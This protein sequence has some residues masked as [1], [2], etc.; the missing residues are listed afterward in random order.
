MVFSLLDLNEFPELLGV[1][2]FASCIQKN[3]VRLY[4]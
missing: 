3:A 2:V 1:I 4:V